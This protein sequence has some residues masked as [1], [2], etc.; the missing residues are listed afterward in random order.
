[1]EKLNKF[2]VGLNEVALD[3]GTKYV[4]LVEMV[5]EDYWMIPIMLVC[6]DGTAIDIRQGPKT[7]L[8]LLAIV[9]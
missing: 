8:P 2:T 7:L 4:F 9:R 5:G 3:A 6:K 1:M